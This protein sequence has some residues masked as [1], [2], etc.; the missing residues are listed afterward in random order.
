MRRVICILQIQENCLTRR[1]RIYLTC[2][3]IMTKI[4]IKEDQHWIGLT[5]G[6]GKHHFGFCCLYMYYK[7]HF[8]LDD[9]SFSLIST[10]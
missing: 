10:K 4:N 8:V 7:M 6:Y 2:H 9:L 1:K 5:D 3:M